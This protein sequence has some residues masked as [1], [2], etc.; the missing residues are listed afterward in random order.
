MKIKHLLLLILI[1]FLIYLDVVWFNSFKYG[2]NN[3]ENG[4]YNTLTWTFLNGI[5][6]IVMFILFIY[7]LKTK[8]YFFETI[9]KYL[10]QKI[11]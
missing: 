5:I 4:A 3:D 10:N 7:Y 6:T 1:V 8:T 11:L 9:N 2:I